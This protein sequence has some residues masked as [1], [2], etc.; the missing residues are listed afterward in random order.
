MTDSPVI[1][2]VDYDAPGR[3]FG[4]LEIP[5]STNESGWSNLFVPLV[6]IANGRGP[7]VLVTGG[8]HGD[9][10]E[11]QVAALN[12]ARETRPEDVRG[13][14]IIIPCLSPEASRAYT[15]L[16]PSGANLNRSFP[17]S[18][19]GTPDEVL[20][21]YV[22]RVLFPLA[23]AVCDIHSGGRSMLC[24]PWSEIHL[25]EHRGQRAAM[26]D[27][28]LAWNTEFHFV[29][30]D[31][32]GGGLL[33][34]EAERQGKI[35]VGTELGG[36]GHVTAETYGLAARGLRNFLRH[37]GVLAGKAETRAALASVLEIA[38][39]LDDTDYRLRALW[40]LWVDRMNASD[41]RQARTLAEGFAR[42]AATA[43]DPLAPPVGDRMIGFALHFLGEQALARRHIERMLAG[44][45]PSVHDRRIVRRFQFDPWV[46]ARSGLATILWLQGYPQQA[47]ATARRAVD[48]AVAAN[49]G[50]TLCNAFAQGICSVSLLTGDLAAA[51]H[52]VTVLLEQ[53]ERHGL[54]F[55]HA[56]GR[57]FKGMLMIRRGDAVAGLQ[58]LQATLAEL[59][60]TS[61]HTR[62]DMFLGAMA[63]ALG[64]AGR[65]GEGL[66]AIDRALDRAK[67]N[68]GLRYVA[69]F[70]RIKGEILLRADAANAATAAEDLFRQ[71]IEL[72]RRQDALSW[73]LRSA[74]S[75][76]RLY[77]R[78]G[79]ATQ[80]SRA[81]APIYRRFTEGF[82]TADL[83]SAKAVLR[84]RG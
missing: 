21:D 43:A 73:E 17:G 49:H 11:G 51:E 6:S 66:D 65:V 39:R 56:D 83:V 5:R 47:V 38:D 8:V 40:G 54:A 4:R 19:A 79:R 9:E 64:G 32:A 26:W 62:Y 57:C 24:L 23:A 59:A 3:Q 78:Q 67:Q 29:Y 37:A 48:E 82:D 18:P 69:E 63:E 60:G 46:T 34:G 55:W 61:F 31:I 71:A 72:G 68:G 7:T 42:A 20:A 80:A 14:L 41:V 27:A 25:V 77:H 15:R 74:T 1:S 10:P 16:W 28:M 75:L 36:G 81:L 50:V 13:R 52:F 53:A 70:L 84:R 76:A 22:T 58:Q 30:I 35:V 12:L 33:V 44:P 45:R 2:T